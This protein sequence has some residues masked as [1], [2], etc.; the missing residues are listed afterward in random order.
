MS[1]PEHGDA[2][3][4][5]VRTR[6]G[7]LASIGYGLLESGQTSGQTE[8]AL[9]RHGHRLGL[10]SLAVSSFGRM[11]ILEAATD[12]GGTVSSSG[13][14]KSLEAIDCTRLRELDR[15]AERTSAAPDA[16]LVG[17]ASQ[18]H[19]LAARRVAERLRAT[20]TPWW[21]STLGLTMLAFFISMQVGVSWQA[22]AAAALVQV[23]SASMGLA[24]GAIRMPRLFAIA[25]QST[26][27]GVFATLLVQWGFVDPV[28]AAAAIAVNWLLLLPLPQVI[29]AV[30][31]AIDGD[32][33][34]AITRVASVGVAGIGI[35]I[36]G[37]LTFELGE[38]LGMEHPRLDG[39]PSMP[40]F[41]V[42]V[43]SALGAIGNAF[44][45]GGRLDLVLPAAT[46]GLVTAAVNQALLWWAGLPAL[47][48]SSLSA[49]VLGLLSARIALRTGY[50]TQV[51]ALMGITGALL[52]GIPVFFGILQEMGG[53]SG[54]SH[55]G[56][57]AAISVGIGA[58][59]A[60]GG[61]LSWLVT[62]RGDGR[63]R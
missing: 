27:A 20:V 56:T 28:G 38:I 51:L 49:V 22:W 23:V 57:A 8:L 42:L 60:L 31:E 32:H 15:L 11:L 62:P 12:D 48:A 47:W 52:P 29:G 44:A 10:N 17:D 21:V 46:L 41:L 14:A 43:F 4:A 58:G 13:A 25:V 59:V 5:D 63:R 55:F 33:L 19:M 45:N 61:Y 54:L 1:R 39:L 16:Q 40:W 18:Q 34:S 2:R 50:P 26:A 35:F 9:R 6:I 36:G 24:V 53:A 30:T 7:F 37:A 3:V